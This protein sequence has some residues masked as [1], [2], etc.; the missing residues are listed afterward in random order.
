M[1]IQPIVND[2]NNSDFIRFNRTSSSDLPLM[3]PSQPSVL[4]S[5]DNTNTINSL[6]IENTYIIPLTQPQVYN[7]HFDSHISDDSYK[8]TNNSQY[9]KY[10]HVVIN[11]D[12]YNHL[13][14]DIPHFTKINHFNIGTL[15]VRSEC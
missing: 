3:N 10:K 11:T 6:D 13:N 8:N 4:N 2:S 1:N 12:C 7:T 15:N 9:S 5:H 14:Q